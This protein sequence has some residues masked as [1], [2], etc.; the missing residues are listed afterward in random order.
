MPERSRRRVLGLL[1]SSTTLLAGSSSLTGTSPADTTTGAEALSLGET[2]DDGSGAAMT[3]QDVT[4][5]RLVRSTTAGSSTHVDVAWL[6]NPQFAVV[7]ADATGVEGPPEFTLDVDGTRYPDEGHHTYRAYPPGVDAGE[8]GRVAIPV[9]IRD[10]ESARVV[11]PQ[12]DGPDASW[13]L[14]TAAVERF[15]RAPDF[16]VRSFA[17][18][19]SVSRGAAF[20]ASFT[21]EN[22]GDPAGQFVAEFGAGS[23]SDFDEVTVTVTVGEGRTHTARVEPHYPES[24]DSIDAVLD[25]GAARL[26]KSVTVE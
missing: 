20:E 24:A 5:H 14:P 13:R 3:V 6:E 2:Y 10:A 9:P 16:S 12:S 21:V 22:T 8:S 26:K 25:W 15:G 19:D 18:P 4:V 23:L 7:E 11:W 17:V 1:G